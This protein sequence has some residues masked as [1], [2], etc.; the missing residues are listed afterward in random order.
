MSKS[1][2]KTPRKAVAERVGADQPPQA[3]FEEVV[4]LI[5]T[6]RTRALAAV[7]TVLIDLYWQIGE[8]I[9]HKIAA[10]GWGKGTVGTLAEYIQ[11]RQPGRTGFSASNLWRMRQFF[12]TYRGARKLAPLVRVL[13]WTHN[14]LVL[15]KCK[16]EEEPEFHLGLA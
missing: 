13:S 15:A 8:Y 9:S 11:R 5:E 6:A 12:E 3:D 1:P 10:E 14:L 4:S 2:R 16:R 7:N